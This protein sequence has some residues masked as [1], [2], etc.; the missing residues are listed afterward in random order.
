MRHYLLRLVYVMVAAVLLVGIIGAGHQAKSAALLTRSVT[1]GTSEIAAT[2]NHNYSFVLNSAGNL[3]SIEF[4]YCANSPLITSP[5]LAPSG[6]DTDSSLLASQSGAVGFS[7]DAALT[8]GNKIVISRPSGPN[9]AAQ[10]AS[11]DFS[12]IINPDSNGQTYV[13]V[14]TFASSDATGPH[15]DDG[16]V[17]FATV[18]KVLVEGFVPPYLTFCTAV[19]VSLDCAS[20]NGYFLNLGELSNTSA[21][22]ATSQ[23]SG[24]TNDPGGFSTTLAGSTMASGTFVIPPLTSPSPSSPGVSQFG[25]NLVAN[26]SPAV[27]QNKVGS[28]S[29]TAHAG[30]NSPNNFKF[31]SELISSSSLPTNFDIFT[32]SYLVNVSAAQHPGVYSATLTY[33]ATAAF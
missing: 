31:G 15:T 4:E 26:S 32:V 25:L 11:Y 28:G 13:R 29:S 18:S 33:I 19:T 17:V 27:G 30:Y 21:N 7:I 6:L 10:P 20:L 5:C 3:G 14:K 12:N 16:A 1:V 22:V 9:L 8:T 23:Y 2:T 24:A